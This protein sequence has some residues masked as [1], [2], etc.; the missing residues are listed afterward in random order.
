VEAKS[1]PKMA[2]LRK[3]TVSLV[4]DRYKLIHYF[5]YGKA[6]DRHELYDI[7]NDPEERQDLLNQEKS[8]AADLQDEMD[9]KVE[10]ANQAFLRE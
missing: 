8:I 6:K 9:S 4:K 3:A 5:G 2:P 10:A 1:N 7:I